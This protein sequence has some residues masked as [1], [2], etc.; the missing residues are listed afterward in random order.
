MEL[1][2]TDAP[3]A[4]QTQFFFNVR[5]YMLSHAEI[6]SISLL[7]HSIYIFSAC[8]ATRIDRN[9]DTSNL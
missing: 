6:G 4:V 9:S 2:V 8:Y 3:A 5:M 1:P 7:G